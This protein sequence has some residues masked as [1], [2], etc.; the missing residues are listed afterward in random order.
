MSPVVLVPVPA[1]RWPV[2]ISV[3]QVQAAE[4]ETSAPGEEKT[5]KE[6]RNMW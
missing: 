2:V 4:R 6:I 1:Y 3:N 5:E